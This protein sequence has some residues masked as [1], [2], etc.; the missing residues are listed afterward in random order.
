MEKHGN[1][2]MTVTA[3]EFEVASRIEAALPPILGRYGL[4]EP[5]SMVVRL[6]NGVGFVRLVFGRRVPGY[7]ADE[8]TER[9]R[10]ILRPATVYP[11]YNV[12]TVQGA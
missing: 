12:V 2:T 10:E 4:A 6:T 3:E 9:V 7:A 8:I 5:L 1:D 11:N